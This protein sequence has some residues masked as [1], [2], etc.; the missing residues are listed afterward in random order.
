MKELD[1]ILA[2]IEAKYK[3]KILYACETGSRAW[4]FPSP[5][6]DYDVRFLYINE[7]DWYLS[8]HEQKDSIEFMD[9]DWDITGW[10]LKKSLLLLK[11]SNAA[12][13]ERF[14]SPIIYKDDDFRNEFRK[15]VD[16]HYNPVA[17]FYHY[18]S[19]VTNFWDDMKDTKE[20]KLKSLMYIVRS[21]L[22]CMWASKDADTLPME[23]QPLMK[24]APDDVK[25]RIKELIVLKAGKNESYL[26]PMDELLEGWITQTMKELEERKSE[27]RIRSADVKS[28]ND[29]FLKI[30]HGS[31]NNR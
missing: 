15:L 31:N 7:P 10:D 26:H 5:D 12:L 4:G 3:I 17:V 23:I 16:E 19:L 8:L 30:W 13:I 29:L 28:L 21:L 18:H 9:G 11:R 27:V 20:V 1:H 14:Q 2:K 6:S 22:C 24:Y 25:Q